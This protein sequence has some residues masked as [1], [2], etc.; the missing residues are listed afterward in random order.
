MCFVWISE[1]TVPFALYSINRLVFITE[2]ESVYC[3]VGFSLTGSPWLSFPRFS[4]VVRQMPGY[5]M[6]SRGAA[7]TPPPPPQGA[8]ASPKRLTKVAYLQ[9]AT[10][11]VC[12]QNPDSQPTKV[13]PP[14]NS[15]VHPRH[16]SLVRSVMALSLTS[17]PYR[18]HIPLL[19]LRCLL[20]SGQTQVSLTDRGAESLPVNTLAWLGPYRVNRE[21][22]FLEWKDKES[23]IYERYNSNK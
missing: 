17:N 3:A 16:Q 6:Q 19:E 4:S 1:Q 7:R 11:P 18:K 22:F 20:Q 5:R 13:I 10:E 21:P 14:I 2:V 9:F 15:S 12:A 8:A 23:K